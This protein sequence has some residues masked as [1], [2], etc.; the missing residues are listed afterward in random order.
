ML[1]GDGP[2]TVFAPTDAAFEKLGQAT[3]DSLL[4]DIPTLTN[5][6][7]YHVANGYVGSGNLVGLNSVESLAEEGA[8]IVVSTNGQRLNG[9]TRFIST[10][11]IAT[12]GV[13]HVIDTVLIPPNLNDP[14]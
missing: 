9:N 11:L 3:L 13:V 10:D 8:S 2:F 6:L 4:G 7:L 5:I 12:N 1:S 14:Q